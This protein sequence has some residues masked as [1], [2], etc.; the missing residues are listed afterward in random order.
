MPN[1][2]LVNRFVSTG[3]M[4]CIVCSNFYFFRSIQTGVRMFF[5]NGDIA[6]IRPSGNAPQVK[7]D[8]M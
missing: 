6:H 4:V 5:D 8:E 7:R 3:P 1:K 2:V